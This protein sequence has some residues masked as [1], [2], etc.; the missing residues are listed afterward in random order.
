MISNWEPDEINPRLNPGYCSMVVP[1]SP[2]LIRLGHVKVNDVVT[3]AQIRVVVTP[4]VSVFESK[5]GKSGCYR[6]QFD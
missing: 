3:H 1:T 4:N 5:A 2:D 6:T